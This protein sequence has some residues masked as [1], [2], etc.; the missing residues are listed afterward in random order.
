MAGFAELVEYFKVTWQGIGTT[1]D[2]ADLNDLP[3]VTQLSGFV[4]FTCNASGPIKYTGATEPFDLI[5]LRRKA[6]ITNGKLSHNDTGYVMLEAANEYGNPSDWNW[7][8]EFDLYAPT[9][10]ISMKGFDIPAVPGSEVNLTVVSPVSVGTGTPTIIG[11]QGF[12]VTGVTIVDGNMLR[13]ATNNPDQ[14]LLPDVEVPAVNAAIDAAGVAVLAA[15]SADASK[16]IATTKAGEA[17][18][19]A[20][21]ATT[22]AGIATTKA[23][24]A[25]GSATTAST[26]AGI[27]TTKAGEASTSAGTATTQAGIA[28]TKAGEAS[29]SAGTATTQ[30][31]I[32]TTKAGEAAGSA[33]TA[34]TAAGTATTKAGEAAASA[35]AAYDAQLA[36]EEAASN[37]SE[38]VVPDNAVSTI[39]IQNDAVTSGKLAPSVRTSLGKADTAL[40]SIAADSIT[41]AMLTAGARTSLGKADTALQSIADDS[42][43]NAKLTPGA[44]TSLGKADT[45][46]QK[47]G[48]G[49]PGSDLSLV[50]LP[51]DISIMACGDATN[52]AVGY[53]QNQL[54]IKLPRAIRISKITYRTKTA[55]ANDVSVGIRKNNAAHTT[56]TGVTITPANQGTDAGVSNTS[57]PWDYAA[58][59]IL[60]LYCS[61]VGASVPKGLIADITAVT[62]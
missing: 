2:G 8:V 34:N 55:G 56:A 6:K 37:A 40:Q 20:G 41:N 31:G 23:G 51:Y 1:D 62:L 16:T 26:Q 11:P 15:E 43:T 18:T 33:T 17:N 25:A 12:Y 27:A 42:I 52:V 39:K 28:T 32:A 61:A 14:P 24:E 49:I 46:Y 21:T 29:T 9:G 10:K 3:D 36:A 35:T 19:S 59:D 22:Q 7:H 47:P 44:R 58:G 50:G 45:A 54:G 30:A 48:G 53:G 38:G 60:N 57:G 13:F 5:P 4:V